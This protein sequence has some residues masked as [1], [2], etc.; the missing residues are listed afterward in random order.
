MCG[1]SGVIGHEGQASRLQ[2]HLRTSVDQLQCRGPDDRG[3]HIEDNALLGQTR[4]SIIDLD[5]GKQPI[6]NEDRSI[7]IV[8]NGEIY[9]YHNLREE[10]L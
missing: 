4:L 7:V 5:T 10:L 9:K 1:I 2:E 3:Y 6:Y 8:F